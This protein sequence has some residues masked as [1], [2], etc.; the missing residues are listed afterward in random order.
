MSEIILALDQGTTGTTVLA[1]DAGTF[2]V[3]GRWTVEVPQHFPGP[4]QV[5]HD[6]EDLWS[7]AQ[8][9]I[10]R[11]LE[12]TGLSDA[13]ARVRAIGITNQ[14][15]TT[16]LWDRRTGRAVHRAIV[17]QD[18]RTAPMCQRL[19]EQGV[20]PLVFDK[21]GLLLDPYFSGTKL[22]WLLDHVP[23]AAVRAERGELAFGTV[24]AWMIHR[25]TGGAE[26]VTDVTNASRTLLMDL[27]TLA[28]DDALCGALGIP[29]GVLPRIAASAEVVGYTRGV[30]G[31]PDGVPIA[32]IAGD[33]QAALFG[34]GCFARGDVKCTYGTG[35]FALMNVGPSPI[36]SR[37]RLLTTVAWK[38][39]GEV[40]YALEGSSFIAGAA[41]QWLRDGLGIIRSA[42]E[43]EALARSV[44]GSGECVF[45]PAL[46]GLGAPHW[47]PDARGLITGIGRDTTR[48]HLA[49][50]TLE[51]IALSIADLLD[52]MGRDAGAPVGT[53][54][55]DGGASANDLLMEIQAALVGATVVR[56]RVVE[57]TALGAGLLAALGVGLA[58]DRG[59]LPTLPVDRTFDGRGVSEVGPLR[60]RWRVA[61]RRAL[62]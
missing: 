61:V 2:E 21:A 24:D 45:V 43:I 35:A 62:S 46:T 53:M 12:A 39:P 57:T 7:G 41:V 31:L 32:G 5:E 37:H 51:G 44:E 6:P 1:L 22:R 55:V 27:R 11:A 48:A 54:K 50:A 33:Q 18:R 20:E 36:P 16:V 28:W 10:R 30:E 56:P 4:G 42:G 9:A 52:A 38:I 47:A 8:T 34:Q 58:K 3:R 15:E 60:A 25:L 49:R 29:S 17:W 59:S 23:D 13:G 19:R 40:A 26:H 14:R